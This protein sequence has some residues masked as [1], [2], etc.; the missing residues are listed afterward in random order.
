[1]KRVCI[2]LAL[3]TYVCYNV[4]FKKSKTIDVVLTR[5][6]AVQFD[7]QA[8]RRSFEQTFCLHLQGSQ[9]I[10]GGRTSEHR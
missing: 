4:R 10:K 9:S 2:W 1:M 7:S 8:R 5:Y 3:I 6:N